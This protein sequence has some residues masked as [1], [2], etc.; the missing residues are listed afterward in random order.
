VINRDELL[1]HVEWLLD[2]G[3][4]RRASTLCR[5]AIRRYPQ[6][7]DLWVALGD[8]LLDSDRPQEGDRSF[9]RAAELS[10]DWALPIAKRAEA[11]LML[12]KI[13][14]AELLAGQAH[15]MDRD[16]PLASFIKAVCAELEGKEDEA[17][18]WYHRA[19][20]LEPD[21]YFAP[22]KV[23]RQRFMVEMN[24]ALERL[25][26]D[27]LVSYLLEGTRWHVLDRV[28]RSDEA[29]AKVYPLTPCSLVTAPPPPTL[30]KKSGGRSPRSLEP[31]VTDGYLFAC[32]IVRECR[33][34]EDLNQ[35]IFCCILDEVEGLLDVD[36][37][38]PGD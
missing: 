19:E 33:T 7:P 13:N 5:R 21:L 20:K 26:E 31:R 36:V 6:D 23:S 34:A 17:W 22:P 14:R 16:L 32:N 18:F 30:V 9:R 38:D 8:S 10:P 35:Q 29:F 24:S 11:Q 37:E 1:E 25:G 15:G 27:K 28:D 4:A 2:E 3:Q 12:G